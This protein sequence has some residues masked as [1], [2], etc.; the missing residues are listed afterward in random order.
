MSRPARADFRGA[1]AHIGDGTKRAL[2][3][4]VARPAATPLRGLLTGYRALVERDVAGTLRL[5]DTGHRYAQGAETTLLHA[6]LF[7]LDYA[8]VL[9][10][11]TLETTQ[12][13]VEA[14][15]VLVEV[16]VTGTGRDAGTRIDF[17]VGHLWWIHADGSVGFQWFHDP[18][19][20]RR[21]LRQRGS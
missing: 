11:P 14:S 9:L 19:D 15:A 5:L 21:A 1:G 17:S 3:T 12:V 7:V 13:S 8:E 6:L 20:A 16:R 18:S 4:A 2:A 10:E